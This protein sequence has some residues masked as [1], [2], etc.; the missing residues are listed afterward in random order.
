LDDQ[1]ILSK[2]TSILLIT[3]VL[4]LKALLQNLKKKKFFAG[5][6]KS[7][8]APQYQIEGRIISALL[9]LLRWQCRLSAKQEKRNQ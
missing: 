9:A 7:S 8:A 2:K 3:H 6:I 5:V 1:E 4:C